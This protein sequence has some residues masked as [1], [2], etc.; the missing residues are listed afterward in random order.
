[1]PLGKSA[2][3]RKMKL[4]RMSISIASTSWSLFTSAAKNWSTLVKVSTPKRCLLIR[5]ISNVET[6]TYLS[7]M[8]N[9]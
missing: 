1:M 4:R 2:L 6:P 8:V 3:L 9:F 7:S 5:E